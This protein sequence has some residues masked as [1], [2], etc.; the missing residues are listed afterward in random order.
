ML[1]NIHLQTEHMI[2]CEVRKSGDK[3]ILISFFERHHGAKCNC[4]DYHITHNEETTL[5]TILNKTISFGD[6][7][8]QYPHLIGQALNMAQY[9]INIFQILKKNT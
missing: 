5:R 6:L 3:E 9:I 1:V 8:V 4:R 7:E 2:A